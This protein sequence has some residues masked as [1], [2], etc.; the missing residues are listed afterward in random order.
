M[1]L[2]RSRFYN[3]FIDQENADILFSRETYNEYRKYCKRLHVAPTNKVR[4][5]REYK[6]VIH[7]LFKAIVDLIIEKESGVLIKGFGYFFVFRSYGHI[8]K[9]TQGKY[10]LFT[11]AYGGM[12]VRLVFLSDYS[13]FHMPFWS[14]EGRFSDYLQLAVTEQAKEGK[15]YK[16]YPYTMRTMIGRSADEIYRNVPKNYDDL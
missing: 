7:S 12:R 11:L 6:A 1:P 4:E 16:G 15:K 5:Y 9:M 8:R 3:T 10:K 13:D 2:L 14:F